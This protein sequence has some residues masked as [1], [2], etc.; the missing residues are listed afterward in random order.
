[1]KHLIKLLLLIFLASCSLLQKKTTEKFECNQINF[2]A[3]SSFTDSKGITYFVCDKFA[4]NAIDS[5]T[6][7]TVR[8]KYS[9]FL[10]Q[11]ITPTRNVHDTTRMDTIYKF[12]DDKTTISFYRAKH[13]DFLRKFEVSDLLFNLYGCVSVG[14]SKE[15]LKNQ[16]NIKKPLSDTIRIG[17]DEQ[18]AIFTLYFKNNKI[19]RIVSTPYID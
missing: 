17:N 4:N 3:D 1:M 7:E 5:Y 11:E 15:A 16:F 10:K 12:Y 2:R 18:T 19:N 9:G 6:I 8:E 13:K 14:M